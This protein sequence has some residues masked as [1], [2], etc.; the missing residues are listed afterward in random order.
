M[1][2]QHCLVEISLKMRL[3]NKH[4][5]SKSPS[6]SVLNMK[7]NSSQGVSRVRPRQTIPHQS[8]LP[9]PSPK[10]LNLILPSNT[11]TSCDF[12]FYTQRQ[13]HKKIYDSQRR[14]V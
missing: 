2:S 5:S 6:N 10:Y 11:A 8:I 13:R 14:S 3:Y 4:D 12:T 1:K 7:I 9:M